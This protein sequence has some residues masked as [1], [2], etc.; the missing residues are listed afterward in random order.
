[1]AIHNGKNIAI[2]KNFNGKKYKF[3]AIYK[4]STGAKKMIASLKRLTSGTNLYRT[5]GIGDNEFVIYSR[6]KKKTIL[7]V[8][9]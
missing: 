1:M 2:V 3:L 4:G 8:V 6:P 7:K 9:R 5:I